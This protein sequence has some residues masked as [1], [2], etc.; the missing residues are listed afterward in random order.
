MLDVDIEMKEEK[1]EEEK[2]ENEKTTIET[3]INHLSELSWEVCKNGIEQVNC[4]RCLSKLI[5]TFETL[6]KRKRKSEKKSEKKINKVNS[7]DSSG[8]DFYKKI[9]TKENLAQNLNYLRKYGIW[10]YSATLKIETHWSRN[11]NILNERE[12]LETVRIIYKNCK[13]LVHFDEEYRIWNLLLR[14][15]SVGANRAMIQWIIKSISYLELACPD[16]YLDR[17]C[18]NVFRSMDKEKKN[19]I[20]TISDVCLFSTSV[21]TICYDYLYAVNF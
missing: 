14:R 2:L 9:L 6:S 13:S 5:E 3:T 18:K 11:Y 4:K 1:K 7:S 15:F 21:A 10:F 16:E 12:L 19:I 8:S 20:D 17:V